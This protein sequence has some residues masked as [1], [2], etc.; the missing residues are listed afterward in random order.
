VIQ[1]DS[2]RR[3]Y[4]WCAGFAIAFAYIESSV[5]VYLRFLYYPE[6]F[7]FPL[8]LMGLPILLTEACRE[9]ATIAV[10]VALSRLAEKTLKHR[11]FLFLYCFGIWDI[12]YYL[13]LK[14]IVDWPTTLFDWDVL[15]LIPLPWVGPVLSPILISLLFI[16]AAVTINHLESTGRSINFSPLD[17]ITGLAAVLTVIGS[18]LWESGSVLRI[19][20]PKRYPWWL[21]GIGVGIGLAVF[22]RRTLQNGR[23]ALS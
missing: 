11:I 22:L 20:I 12:F 19:A 17:W 5:V 6:G 18:F 23:T 3:R 15:F 1:A 7:S 8:K 10:L 16:A 4:G 14:V 13:W 9:V 2:W 21:W